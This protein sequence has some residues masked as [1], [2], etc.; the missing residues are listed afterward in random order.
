[1]AVNEKEESGENPW[2]MVERIKG[3]HTLVGE[4]ERNLRG[5]GPWT[6]VDTRRAPK[7]AEGSMESCIG[8]G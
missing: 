6:K 1:M 5:G 7:D 8:R 3:G 4:K 2:K